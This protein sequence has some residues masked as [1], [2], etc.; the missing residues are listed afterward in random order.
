[1]S[2]STRLIGREQLAILGGCNLNTSWL[3][4][5]CSEQ[6][7][8]VEIAK[9][10]LTKLSLCLSHFGKGPLEQFKIS[11]EE[12]SLHLSRYNWK[13]PSEATEGS[14]EHKA[15]LKICELAVKA[16]AKGHKEL[17]DS[18]SERKNLTVALSLLLKGEIFSSRRESIEIPWNK[19][20][21][22][23]HL[24]RI[25]LSLFPNSSIQ[26]LDEKQIE[27]PA[28][29]RLPENLS[30]LQVFIKQHFFASAL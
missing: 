10:N 9:T 5:D 12:V 1:M 24:K 7:K 6:P 8:L 2:S 26:I 23:E 25:L 21:T 28:H 20:L 11:L 15:Y 13:G 22:V 29:F 27:I 4:I 16:F 14:L 19:E 30:E 18:I 3:A 17:L